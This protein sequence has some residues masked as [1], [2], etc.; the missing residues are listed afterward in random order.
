MLLGA[1]QRR[2]GAQVGAGAAAEVDDGHGPPAVEVLG[3]RPLESCGCG[4]DGRRRLAQVEPFGSEA[5]HA[6][7][8]LMTPAMMRAVSSQRGSLWP[9]AQDAS[10]RRRRSV[11]LVEQAADG[12]G[13]RMLVARRHLDG[14]G[15]RRRLRRRAAGRADDRQAARHRLGQHHAVALV[16]GRQDEEH[17][18]RRTSRPAPRCATAPTMAMRSSSPVSRTAACR[19]ASACGLRS[20]APAMVRRQSRSRKGAS[21]RTRMS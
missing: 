4:S 6:A 16:E 9:A 20:V 11:G 18:Q 8:S 19:A 3:E 15:I 13:E 10:A 2:G 7:S 5:A 17:R 14:R 12:G 1:E 21:A